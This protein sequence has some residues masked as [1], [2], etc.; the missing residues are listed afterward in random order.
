MHEGPQGLLL[1]F[2]YGTRRIGVAVGDTVTRTARPLATVA[3]RKSRPEWAAIGR[4]LDAWQPQRLVVGLPVD[5]D[6]AEQPASEG[7]RRFARQLE[8]RYRLPVDL[9]DERLT[10][11]AALT[12]LA[13]AGRFREPVDPVAAQ[14]IL[15]GWFSERGLA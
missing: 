14:I 10:S 15:E 12:R 3:V 4:L 13:E 8:G 6:G 7:A 5:L 9:V 11:R 1:G 2:D